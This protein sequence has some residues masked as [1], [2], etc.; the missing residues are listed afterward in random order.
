MQILNTFVYFNSPTFF[1][2]LHLLIVLQYLLNAEAA[3]PNDDTYKWFTH[4]L[5]LLSN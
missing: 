1:I 3:L 5:Y 4:L 2:M